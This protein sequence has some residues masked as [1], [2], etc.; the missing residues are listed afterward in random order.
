VEN[1]WRS[2][3]VEAEGRLSTRGFNTTEADDFG[4]NRIA[5]VWAEPADGNCNRYFGV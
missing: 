3:T 5:H 4:T 2:G 1:D